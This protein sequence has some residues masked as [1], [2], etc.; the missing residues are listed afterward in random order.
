LA[1]TTSPLHRLTV[2]LLLIAD[3]DI[4]FAAP[5]GTT[6]VTPHQVVQ[7][8]IGGMDDP[9][10]EVRAEAVKAMAAVLVEGFGMEQVEKKE[11]ERLGAGLI[12]KACEVG[13]SV[14]G[15]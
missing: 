12:G 11:R 6:C 9:V 10:A 5:S 14:C 13:F 7:V 2:Y 4:L 8:L 1:A 15:S 3:P